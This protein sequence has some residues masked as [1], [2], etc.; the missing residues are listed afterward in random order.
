MEPANTI[1]AALGGPSAVAS[2]IGIHRTRVSKWKA[3]KDKGGTGGLIP[4][5]HVPDL[6]KMGR[7][8]GVKLSP[9]DF[10]AYAFAGRSGAA[11]D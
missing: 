2:R 11:H 4:Q 3:P 8:R 9:A 5:R 6:V 1:I 7:E 10:L